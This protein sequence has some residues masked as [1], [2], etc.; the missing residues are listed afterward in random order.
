MKENIR[1]LI[2]EMTL[3]EKA[4]L[5]SGK[6]FWNLK[7]IERLGI[8]EIMVTDG[9][10]GLRKQTDSADHLGLNNSVPATCF[11]SG[12]GLAATWN[13]ELL[14]SV[15]K[16]LGM[17]SKA[18]EVDV[19]L[20]PAVNIKRSPLCGRNFEYF[21][22]DP[23]LAGELAVEHINGTQ[24]EGVGTSLKHFAANNQETNR[25]SID[26]LVDERTLREIYLPAFEVAI[27]RAQPWTVMCAYNKLNGEF[28]SEHRWLLTEI[29]KEE[30][31]HEGIVVTDW[32]AINE[33]VNGLKAGLELEMPASGGIN[34]VKIVAAVKSGELDESILNESVSRILN[35]IL[36]SVETRKNR[37]NI[38]SIEKILEADHKVA[39]EASLESMVLLKNENNI[40]PLKEKGNI[41]F[42]GAFAET[43]RYQGGGSSHI[44]PSQIDS[45]LDQARILLRDK[46]VITYSPGYDPM[47]DN[48]DE[49]LIKD[50]VNTAKESDHVVLFIGLTDLYESEGFDRTHMR[51]PPG[52]AR[53]IEEISAV[54][55][56]PVVV[57][58]NGSAIE[59][60]WISK[61][62]AVIESY[63][64]G[65]G[66]GTA[67]VK[68]LFGHS[69]PSGKLPETFPLRLKDNSSAINFPGDARTVEY[70]EGIFVGYRG[71]DASEQHVLFPFGHGLSYTTFEYSNMFFSSSEI[72]ENDTLEVRVDIKNIGNMAGKEIIQIYV[73]DVESSVLRP[74]KELKAFDKVHL[75]PGECKTI[76]FNLNRRSFAFWHPKLGGWRVESGEFNILAGASSRDIRLSGSVS[77][78]AERWTD[79]KYNRETRLGEIIDHPIAGEKVSQLLTGMKQIFGESSNEAEILM[80]DAMVKEMPLK[81]VVSFS[82]GN[83]LNEDQM[84]DILTILN[85]GV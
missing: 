65:Q 19:I 46:A 16:A 18:Y 29:L 7:G 79:I 42:I 3:E 33:R 50:A 13:R 39:I 25:M 28:C 62:S 22:E 48:I 26:T 44:N 68:T 27:K 75:N 17:E 10:H 60:P 85:K 58:S 38:P 1:D 35:I 47:S 72:N 67:I 4:G 80:M 54:I 70:R 45:A 57:L 40:L 82:S 36:K 43:P 52:H 49:Q 64:G 11:P 61:T 37:K 56:D 21:S 41:A 66:W 15:G 34:D 24:S 23:Y 30:W 59:M 20:G 71:Y 51:I 74:V 77:I 63:L 53:L 83:L 5:C 6:D 84:E 8:P 78:L 2:S 81:S 76:T 73:H 31:G 55:A 69:N 14:H 12:A 9:P 32:G